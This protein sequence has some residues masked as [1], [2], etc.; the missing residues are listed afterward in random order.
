MNRTGLLALV[1]LL[2]AGLHLPRAQSAAAQ[3]AALDLSP[4]GL[5]DAAIAEGRLQ[6]A[7]E[8][9][10]RS[11]LEARDPELRLR[12]AEL[13]L[14]AGRM[15]EALTGFGLLT[16]EPDVAARALAGLGVARLRRDQPALAVEALDKA[17]KL[18]A[19]QFRAVLARAVA[20]D[21]LR[22]WK[23]ADSGYAA[24]LA[25]R[26]GDAATL[27]NRGWSRLLRG[28]HAEA[29]ADFRAA[30]A[31]EPDNR[32]VAGNLRLARAMQGRYEEAFSGS[33]RETLAA[34][35]NTVGFAAMARGD[36]D[37]AEAYFSRAMALN[38]RFDRQADA[39][40]KWLAAER[41][42]RAAEPAAR[43]GRP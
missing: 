15:A 23:R 17:L 28:L 41:K 24:A 13:A 9:I 34:D 19:G 2:A 14:A 37:V 29:E 10:R 42:R 20:A 33:S 39:N 25:L 35:L 1:A 6:D 27:S 31:T 3:E 16:E 4:L 5:I 43:P 7:E 26:P 11:P 21:R 8:I 32:V 38:P 40:L 36:L 12:Q 30:L 22:D 18:D